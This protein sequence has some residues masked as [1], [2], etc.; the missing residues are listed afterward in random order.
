MGEL[1]LVSKE[2]GELHLFMETKINIPNEV[3]EKIDDVN[4]STIRFIREHY[5]IHI[6]G[7]VIL[8]VFCVFLSFYG[9]SGVFIFIPAISVYLFY[10]HVNEKIRHAFMQQFAISNGYD[11]HEK[12]STEEFPTQYLE[13]GRN[14]KIQDVVRGNYHNCPIIFFN[15]F[16]DIRQGDN[17]KEI[18]F[19]VC[20]IQYKTDLPRIFLDSRKHGLFESNFFRKQKTEEFISLEGDFDK[21]FALYVPRGYE[22][23]VLEIFAPDIMARLIDNAKLFNLE[24]V[25]NRIYIYSFKQITTKNDLDSLLDLAKML[26]LELA[27]V[28]ERIENSRNK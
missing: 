3:N 21:H 26:I 5:L 17:N 24:F 6:I 1:Q 9:Q 27:P 20:S 22:V 11:F 15:F 28:L 7:L 19:T 14:R 16:C 18:V 8:S 23:E 10:R 13:S 2:M 4:K 12:G 25:G